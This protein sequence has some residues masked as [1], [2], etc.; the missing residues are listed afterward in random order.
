MSNARSNHKDDHDVKE[1]RVLPSLV[2]SIDS[3]DK[4]YGKALVDASIGEL[5]NVKRSNNSYPPET[6]QN[7]KD[8]SKFLVMNNTE[9]LSVI[10]R[11]CSLHNY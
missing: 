7:R 10:F 6:S 2:G 4:S 8:F 1:K 3:K 11:W 5:N 9:N